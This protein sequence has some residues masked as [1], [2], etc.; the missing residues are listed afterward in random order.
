MSTIT[1][2]EDLKLKSA[3]PI[4]VY[5]YHEFNDL[6]RSQINLSKNTISFLL[7]GTKE[8]ITGKEST[9]IGKDHFLIMKSG[10]CLMTEKI[11]ANNKSYKSILLFFTDEIL[12]DFFEKN[13]IKPDPNISPK[14]FLVGQYDSYIMNFVK[15]LEGLSKMKKK[16]QEKLLKTKFEEIMLYLTEKE[17]SRFLNS[18]LQ[19]RNNPSSEISKIVENNKLNKLTLQE[20]AFLC[21]M[22]LSTFKREFQKHY[23]T[24]PI[25]WFREKRLEHS[26]YLLSTQKKR[27]IEIFEE[28]GYDNLSSFVQAFKTQYGITPKQYQL[29][30]L[31]F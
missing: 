14:P 21:H 22:S 13:K 30:N 10:H 24:T 2:P 15:S 18:I 11:S 29:D 6:S 9:V 1:L 28:M 7:A 3:T 23:K 19:K 20:L 25:K 31:N 27:P 8:L 12:N 4:Q 16:L 17:G 26:A 5:N